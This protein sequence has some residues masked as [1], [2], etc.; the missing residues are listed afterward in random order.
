MD[1]FLTHLSWFGYR[2]LCNG[3][4]P[5]AI[6]IGDFCFPFCQRCTSVFIGIFIGMIL[7]HYVHTNYKYLIVM[8]PMMIDGILSNFFNIDNGIFIRCMTGFLFG[9]GCAICVKYASDITT[10]FLVSK[11]ITTK[12]G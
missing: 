3:Y 9:I 6:F 1:I 8:V 11:L 4:L 7:F 2:P 5:H 12:K 10:N